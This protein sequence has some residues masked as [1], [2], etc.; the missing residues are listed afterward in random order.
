MVVSIFESTVLN[1]VCRN[2]DVEMERM[3]AIDAIDAMTKKKITY[4]GWYQ[5]TARQYPSC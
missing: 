1:M 5:D 2:I 3:D 4:E